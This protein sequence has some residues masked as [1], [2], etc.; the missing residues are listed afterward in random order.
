MQYVRPHPKSGPR[1]PRLQPIPILL[2]RPQS[3]NASTALIAI[4][5]SPSQTILTVCSKPHGKAPIKECTKQWERNCTTNLSQHKSRG[6]IEGF[7]WTN[8][9]ADSNDFLDRWVIELLSKVFEAKDGLKATV[10]L[11]GAFMVA[12]GKPD[13]GRVRGRV[14]RRDVCYLIEMRIGARMNYRDGA[15]NVV[16]VIYLE[17]SAEWNWRR[18]ISKIE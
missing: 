9:G 12:F 18:T 1:R 14:Q 6:V 3:T 15:V 17:R 7:V 5:A 13:S 2:L 11:A 10:K 16:L 4:F 8:D